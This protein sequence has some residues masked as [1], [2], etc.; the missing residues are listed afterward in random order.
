[1]NTTSDTGFLSG[2]RRFFTL[3]TSGQLL[4]EEQTAR[5]RARKLAAPHGL[6]GFVEQERQRIDA[7]V[8]TTDQFLG[9]IESHFGDYAKFLGSE[10]DGK[11][12]YENIEQKFRRRFAIKWVRRNAFDKLVVTVGFVY[13]EAPDHKVRIDYVY[14]LGDETEEVI[15]D[16]YTGD[17]GIYKKQDQVTDNF[18][19]VRRYAN[20]AEFLKEGSLPVW[21][22]AEI[23]RWVTPI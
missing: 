8:E 23:D 10:Y 16:N 13:T 21:F 18:R 9:D 6:R 22:K 15:N 11:T 20:H 3:K 12:K 4:T 2:L 7:L 5:S 17:N 19:S 1:M 14:Q